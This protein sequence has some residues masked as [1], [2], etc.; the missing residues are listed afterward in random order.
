M[1]VFVVYTRAYMEPP[2]CAANTYDVRV[3]VLDA[4]MMHVCAES[5][6]WHT[7]VSRDT[8]RALSLVDRNTHA[9]TCA[10]HMRWC[11]R[12]VWRNRERIL[13]SI[14]QYLLS[15]WLRVRAIPCH[16][17]FH[18]PYTGD[19]KGEPVRKF[20]P[21]VYPRWRLREL[22]MFTHSDDDSVH[23]C[24]VPRGYALAWLCVFLRTNARMVLAIEYANDTACD[25]VILDD[26]NIRGCRSRHGD[27]C[28]E[29]NL[30]EVIVYGGRIVITNAGDYT[31]DEYGR[32]VG[33]G[34]G[35]V[36]TSVYARVC[37]MDAVVRARVDAAVCRCAA[38]LS[39]D[40]M[41]TYMS[42]LT[43]WHQ[44]LRK[45]LFQ[46][47]CRDAH[48]CGWNEEHDACVTQE[49]LQNHISTLQVRDW[50]HTHAQLRLDLIDPM[51]ARLE[52]DLE[53]L[54]HDGCW[55]CPIP[56]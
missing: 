45:R 52:A 44:C 11:R 40:A 22:E 32:A 41:P 7:P 10:I 21:P 34:V 12:R 1:N 13:A 48:M 18:H 43:D 20:A 4:F 14:W 49:Y 47:R 9:W 5:S 54:V 3:D 46:V 39:D 6:F 17:A 28:A 25:T 51:L 15:P 38:C 2:P 35:N 37:D 19:G 55:C 29:I 16:H 30:R 27:W 23:G 56:R 50:W 24:K 42:T 36:I 31:N 33:R 53:D 8:L 26:T